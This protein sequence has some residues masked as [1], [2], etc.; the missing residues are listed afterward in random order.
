VQSID[1]QHYQH[2][3]ACREL[4]AAYTSTVNA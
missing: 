1:E 3:N 2:G 4:I